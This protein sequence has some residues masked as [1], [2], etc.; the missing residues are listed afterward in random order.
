[1]PRL[2]GKT[3]II[4]GGARGMGASH[5][6]LFTERGARVVLMD[7]L[8]E[9]GK[10]LAAELGDAAVFVEADVTSSQDWKRVVERAEDTFGT[11]DVLVNNAGILMLHRLETAT[12]ADFRRTVEVNQIGVFL[13]MQAVVPTMRRAGRG[14]IVNIGSTAG[15]VGYPDC[16]AYA[17]TKWA[18]RGMTKTA[19]AELAPYGIRV[20]AVHPGDVETPMT[21]D[22]RAGGELTT[23]GIPLG[24]FA[25]PREVSLAVLHLASNDSSYT[26]GADVAVDGAYTA[27]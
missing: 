8:V 6:R 23:D 2:D 18:I 11:V 1:M 12:E 9:E 21:A 4:S 14:S 24:R 19:A 13:G 16:F 20:N 3:V 26:T 7:R 15:L 27:V 10:S 25:V 17:A 5:A 22:I